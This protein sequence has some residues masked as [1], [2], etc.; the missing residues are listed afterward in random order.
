[1]KFLKKSKTNRLKIER[2]ALLV[3]N[4][5]EI[6]KAVIQECRHVHHPNILPPLADIYES[7]DG[8]S[9]IIQ[10]DS[11]LATPDMFADIL[12]KLPRFAE[13]WRQNKSEELLALVPGPSSQRRTRRGY[14]LARLKLATTAFSCSS[15]HDLISYPRILA[16]SCMSRLACNEAE[17]HRKLL[18]SQP[19]SLGLDH[20]TFDENVYR[21][22]CA[23]IELCD[24]DP[25]ATLLSD[26][27]CVWYECTHSKCLK[28]YKLSG[29]YT[30][31]YSCAVCD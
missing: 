8:V 16:H 6:F 15:C 24:R 23:L 25:N 11:D 7:M 19:W 29:R 22:G 9:A 4:R 30:M 28:N 27:D 20:I 18:N 26:M 31:P 10:A 17:E 2:R 1:M 12:E 3:K 21:L 14:P 5:I 13:H